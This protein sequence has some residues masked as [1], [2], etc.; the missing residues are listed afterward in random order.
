MFVL[1]SSNSRVT[2]TSRTFN[3]IIVEAYSEHFRFFMFVLSKAVE[4]CGIATE[5]ADYTRWG[6]ESILC[7]GNTA[8]NTS[9][10]LVAPAGTGYSMY[11]RSKKLKSYTEESL[12]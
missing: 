8:R 6:C 4:R 11:K 1:I 10:V 9:F 5:A 3:N 2:R 7:I 12:E